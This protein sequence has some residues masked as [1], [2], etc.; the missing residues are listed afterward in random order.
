MNT[1][2]NWSS[3]C[4]Q[5]RFVSITGYTDVFE[6]RIRGPHEVYVRVRSTV[7]ICETE[8]WN[9]ISRNQPN[10]NIRERA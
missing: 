6:K 5:K 9:I 7:F 4:H 3:P 2:K 1:K 10:K 8:G